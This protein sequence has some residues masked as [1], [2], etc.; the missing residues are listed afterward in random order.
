MS[1]DFTSVQL[2]DVSRHF[3]RR[4]ALARVSLTASSGDILGLLGPNGAGKSTLIGV[5][6]TLAAPTSGEVRFGGRTAAEF[7]A[8]LR[9]RIGLLAHELFLY[10]ELSARQNLIF[11]A[12]LYGLDAP[13]LVPA[14][15]VR[16]GLADRADDDV[17]G[18]SRGMRQ[19]LAL[20]RALLHQPRLVLFDEPFTGLDDRAVSLVSDRLREIAAGGAIVVLATHDLDVADGLITRAAVI[21]GG[22]LVAD[23][24]AVSGLRARYRSAI[25]SA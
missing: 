23:E 24:P 2:S 17:S 25:G 16:A 4:R 18:F 7:G 15:L 22:R 14:A 20:E 19:R 5:L 6:A 21:K 11:F 9:A 1:L 12:Q 3:G 10:P 13:S 8:T